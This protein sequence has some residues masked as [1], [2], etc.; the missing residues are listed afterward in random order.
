MSHRNISILLVEDNPG[1]VRLT[2]EALA[3]SGLSSTLHVAG[4]GLQAIRFLSTAMDERNTPLPDLILLDLNLPGM[5]G[6]QVLER[7]KHEPRLSIIPVVVLSTSDSEND[8]RACYAAHA[9]CYI[10]KPAS[11]APFLE[12]VACIER[13][14]LQTARLPQA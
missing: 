7:L 10:T 2:R 8:V 6:N 14:W 1:D 11:Y 5:S 4:D 3:E 13:F 12:A 9:N